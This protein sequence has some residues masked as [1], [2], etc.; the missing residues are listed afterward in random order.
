MKIELP[1]ASTPTL[2]AT[3]AVFDDLREV[4]M[5]VS[6][7]EGV[8]ERFV[9]VAVHADRAFLI[10]ALPVLACVLRQSA[11]AVTQPDWRIWDLFYATGR[12]THGDTLPKRPIIL[13][14][15]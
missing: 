15:T 11:I 4:G 2:R 14:G 9:Q 10:S 5:G 6:E 12:R 8:S 7:W 1:P 3:E 13:K